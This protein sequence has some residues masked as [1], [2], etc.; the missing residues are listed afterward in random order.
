MRCSA[1]DRRAGRRVKVE[2]RSGSGDEEEGEGEGEGE[3]DEERTR[4]ADAVSRDCDDAK[5]GH[6]GG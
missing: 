4:L 3:G 1:E 6:D 5:G 2:P